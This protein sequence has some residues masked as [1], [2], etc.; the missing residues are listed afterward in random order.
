MPAPNNRLLAALGALLA[1]IIACNFPAPGSPAQNG[2]DLILTEAAQTV[3]AQLTLAGAIQATITPGS[4]E[5]TPSP[6]PDTTQT[7][8]D[9]SAQETPTPDT[10][11]PSEIPC[12]RAGFVADV[13]YPDNTRVDP[14]AEF[15]KTWRLRN[16]GSCTWDPGYTVVFDRGDSLDAPAAVPIPG[17]VAPNETVE[18]SVSMKAPDTPGT[19][20][21]YWKLRNPAGVIFGLG[22]QADK[23]FWI[24]IVVGVESG[25][26]YDFIAQASS[27]SWVGSGGGADVNL[28][29]GGADD[30]PNGVAKLKDNIR[31]EDGMQV[32]VTLLTRPKHNNDGRITGTFPEY[33][34]QEGDRIIANLSFLENCGSGRVLFQLRVRDEGVTSTLGEWRKSCDGKIL[35]V[36]LSLSNLRGKQVQFIL[37]VHADGSPVDDLAV[38]GSARIER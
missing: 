13:N 23:D 18:I 22:E 28:N 14:G 37:V 29:F 2:Q 38:W 11:T 9:P 12:D 34:V 36:D 10:G 7:P 35:N 26:A 32:G 19:Y 24:K 15:V 17:L 3:E 25:I 27:A 31:L 21:G 20:Q 16:T 8:G 4:I 1:A 33:T 6:L 5:A 30:D